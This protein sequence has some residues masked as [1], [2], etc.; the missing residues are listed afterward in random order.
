MTGVG[1]SGNVTVGN[2]IGTDVTGTQSIGN[3]WTG[4]LIWQDASNNVVGGTISGAGNVISGNFYPI[5]P[6]GSGTGVGVSIDGP[7]SNGNIVQ[8]NFIGTDL[9]GTLD[10]GNS[11]GVYISGGSSNNIIGGITAE[12]RNIIS[13]NDSVGAIISGTG[14]VVL[15]NYIGTDV[16]GTVAVGNRIGVSLGGGDNTVGGITTGAE[17]HFRKR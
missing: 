14:N 13:G 16:T 7:S 9:T 11:I 10:L 3:T 1:T 4:V 15:G 8:G 5:H 2:Y 6:G 17:R 12:A